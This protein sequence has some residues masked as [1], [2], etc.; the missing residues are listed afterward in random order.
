MWE[1]FKLPRLSKGV[2]RVLRQKLRVQST[3]EK[4]LGALSLIFQ[5][6]EG[7]R[8][9]TLGMNPK[10]LKQLK[11][12]KSQLVKRVAKEDR[13]AWRELQKLVKFMQAS[14]GRYAWDRR[15]SAMLSQEAFWEEHDELAGLKAQWEQR[16]PYAYYS[17]EDLDHL[18][19]KFFPRVEKYIK[20]AKRELD[21]I[22]RKQHNE[23]LQQKVD[24]FKGFVV[25]L[26]THFPTERHSLARAMLTRLQL[27]A[28]HRNLAFDDVLHDFS[29]TLKSRGF[30]PDEEVGLR[31]RPYRR[32]RVA[33][34]RDSFHRFHAFIKRHGDENTK[35]ALEQ[36]PW[37][38]QGHYV[39]DDRSQT[40]GI[41]KNLFNADIQRSKPW[42]G[43]LFR[44]RSARY[45][46]FCDATKYIETRLLSEFVN[47]L[48]EQIADPLVDIGD[49]LEECV[50]NLE[51][52]GK[53]IQEEHKRITKLRKGLKGGLFHSKSKRVLQ[54][55]LKELHTVQEKIMD[56]QLSIVQSALES[57]ESIIN[58]DEKL[59][60]VM[61]LFDRVSTVIASLPRDHSL[62]G[63]AETLRKN[64]QDE[65][66]RHKVNTFSLAV[67]NLPFRRRA[68]Y[69]ATGILYKVADSKQVHAYF[70]RTIKYMASPQA[71]ALR[72]VENILTGDYYREGHLIT[73]Q[74]I[75]SAMQ[76]CF[77]DPG[78]VVRTIIEKILAP[79]IYT[80]DSA[81]YKLL[82][83]CEEKLG[84]S[85]RSDLL[86]TLGRQ[87]KED[88]FLATQDM[89]KENSDLDA[90]T[91][92][93]VNQRALSMD[94][95]LAKVSLLEKP[96][97]DGLAQN[98]LES[99]HG[100]DEN[101]WNLFKILSQ[102]HAGTYA[103]KRLSYLLEQRNYS[104]I[105]DSDCLWMMQSVLE[106]DSERLDAMLAR[107]V[108]TVK[109]ALKDIPEMRTVIERFANP[110]IRSLW[111]KRCEDFLSRRFSALLYEKDTRKILRFTKFLRKYPGFPRLEAVKTALVASLR[112]I[113]HDTWTDAHHALVDTLQDE[114]LKHL[115]Y[116][117]LLR[118]ILT[119][120]EF[121]ANHAKRI[122]PLE[123]DAEVS[124]TVMSAPDF[125]V[126]CEDA[127]QHFSEQPWI[128]N[129][130]GFRVLE[131]L[132]RRGLTD[133][134]DMKDLKEK[135]K[136]LSE[137]FK[138]QCRIENAV[139]EI[140]TFIDN[141]QHEEA[142]AKLTRLKEIFPY[143]Q[144][145]P[146]QKTLEEI[147]T[148]ITRVVGAIRERVERSWQEERHLDIKSALALLDVMPNISVVENLQRKLKNSWDLFALQL[149]SEILA[150]S[151]KRTIL[152]HS[153][154]LLL[155]TR[156]GES[157]L[158]ETQEMHLISVLQEVTESDVF[159]GLSQDAQS[160]LMAVRRLLTD[161]RQEE[162]T[163]IFSEHQRRLM[164]QRETDERTRVPDSLSSD[165]E[166]RAFAL[167]VPVQ[168]DISQK[169][170]EDL[171]AEGLH[172]TARVLM[173]S[174]FLSNGEN[175]ALRE[176]VAKDLLLYFKTVFF[177][178]V[179]ENNI[180]GKRKHAA[181][182]LND[183]RWS[184]NKLGQLP[185]FP[186]VLLTQRWNHIE[187]S[188]NRAI[189]S[190]QGLSTEIKQEV[191][192]LNEFLL[193][194]IEENI[195]DDPTRD[196]WITFLKDTLMSGIRNR[197]Y[198]VSPQL[199]AVLP[200]F[201][202]V[203]TK[204]AS[205]E[206]RQ[207]IISYGNYYADRVTASV[208][209]TQS[210]RIGSRHRGNVSQNA[211]DASAVPSVTN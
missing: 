98:Y 121:A 91:E 84:Q 73:Y 17:S 9:L 135:M 80:T 183:M 57:L 195:L 205:E 48:Q 22:A 97:R 184:I 196:K 44:G 81:G 175:A 33:L 86:K 209:N 55:Y 11:R 122:P 199:S 69:N 152:M 79:S 129:V 159:Y 105:L 78:S 15:L 149:E 146:D 120:R 75:T 112:N 169:I 178:I 7:Y 198:T 103:A 51:E 158:N 92:V 62:V 151:S 21:R 1:K 94:A 45:Q 203:L 107:F 192:E 87:Q 202:R 147:T 208:R 133:L 150:V 167:T 163:T 67:H 154:P 96:V 142:K 136:P 115:Y 24:T 77:E 4:A 8:N 95:F 186:Y 113:P 90:Q 88:L 3:G 59:D 13:R 123:D 187:P 71:E 27:A 65:I 70:A 5:E 207:S 137:K 116:T 50:L 176:S 83:D 76:T 28:K 191:P 85:N 99:F 197:Q 108:S 39:H 141:Q 52:T 200:A 43:W 160:I 25:S 166:A 201:L 130:D 111:E 16:A 156:R 164:E 31:K 82:R 117:S 30:D 35:A 100:A 140:T 41:K 54:A 138:E 193:V 49:L 37:V 40:Y 185:K 128:D 47:T 104:L 165:A 56:S 143:H 172:K 23:T 210:V 66:T 132:L 72:L 101:L 64:L 206:D 14:Q 19:R 102:K 139:Q 145:T 119:D 118:R 173:D 168:D 162:D 131:N 114:D 63:R 153:L 179:K 181:H 60:T 180:S 155:G 68:V 171:Q 42:L 12:E 18:S 109:F 74:N 34:H 161:Q 61:G 204:N 106:K 148:T 2:S 53:S 93:P 124:H 174:V 46:A 190:F 189:R 182:L 58:N 6:F 177:E 89:L 38:Q 110:E 26:E 127:I 29:E 170:I 188:I 144:E 194:I 36:L 211:D 134:F 20:G 10:A 125:R 157:L 126:V 32:A